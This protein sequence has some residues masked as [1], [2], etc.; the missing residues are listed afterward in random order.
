MLF[1][2]ARLLRCNL[3]QFVAQNL[4]VIVANGSNHRDQGL[5]HIGSVQ[6]ATKPDFED[7]VIDLLARKI[8]Q[9]QGSSDLVGDIRAE[10]PC[11]FNSL[12]G[13]ADLWISSPT[14]CSFIN[15]PLTRIRSR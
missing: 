3:S 6:A 4:H 14:S 5:R 7:C 13:G 12:Y 8:E 15:C 11:P 2:D 9:S 10:F 1:D